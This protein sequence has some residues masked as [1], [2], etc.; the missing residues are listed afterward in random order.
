MLD[1]DVDDEDDED[2]EELA[3]G[4]DE[5]LDDELELE[6]DMDCWVAQPDASI[7]AAAA[8]NRRHCLFKLFT[9]S[10][11]P[12]MRFIRIRTFF[13]I[14]WW[15]PVHHFLCVA[16]SGFGAGFWWPDLSG[17]YR[18]AAGFPPPGYCVPGRF[19]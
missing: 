17:F 19:C 5:G 11:P 18:P 3:D 6:D 12:S 10:F 9:S 7:K 2:D 14:R 1:E 13:C 8:T 15:Q 16:G 4:D